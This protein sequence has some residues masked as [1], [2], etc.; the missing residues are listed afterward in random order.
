MASSSR[1][2]LAPLTSTTKFN[3]W[4]VKMESILTSLELEESILGVNNITDKDDAEKKKKDAKAL[5]QVRLHLSNEIL[6][7]VIKEKTTKDLWERLESLLM[8]KTPATRLYA[9]AR[10]YSHRMEGKSLKIYLEEFREIINN[11]ENLG[12]KTDDEDLAMLLLYHLPSTYTH[13]F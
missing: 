1:I 9:K 4:Q 10:L 7:Q 13:T 2:D 11:L 3:L 5:A 8:T 12:V 6:Q